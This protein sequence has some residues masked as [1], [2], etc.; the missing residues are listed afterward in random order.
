MKGARMLIIPVLL[1]TIYLL[2]SCNSNKPS[3]GDGDQFDLKEI[4]LEAT[5]PEE[6]ILE[7][8][9]QI[10]ETVE[11]D[12]EEIEQPYQTCYSNS[13]ECNQQL[14]GLVGSDGG[15]FSKYII[16]GRA[17]EWQEPA[18]EYIFSFTSGT[19]KL[20]EVEIADGSGGLLDVIVLD[21]RC[22]PNSGINF[23]DS[24]TRFIA[25]AE[26]TYFIVIDGREEVRAPF[27]LMVTCYQEFEICDNSI[28]DDN[29]TAIDCQDT[30]CSRSPS[31]WELDCAD[32]DDDDA[33][34]DID[35][36]DWDCIGAVACTGGDGEIGQSCISHA[37]C[38]TG[39]CLMEK[40]TGWPGG[41]C[42]QISSYHNCD[43][44]LCGEG[45]SCWNISAGVTGPW[46]CLQIATESNPCR[47]GYQV[48]DELCLPFCTSAAQCPTLGFCDYE[49]GLCT[50]TPT[51]ICY[52][53]SDDD[54]DELVDCEDLD[55][56]FRDECSTPVPLPG[57][58]ACDDA[59]QI[60]IPEG[61]NTTITIEGDT[62]SYED[63]LTPACSPNDSAD[64]VYFIDIQNSSHVILD[65]MGGRVAP[66]LQ[67][68]V[69]AIR[70]ECTSTDLACNND[71]VEGI[72]YHSRIETDL[73]PGRYYII[74]D[75]FD[76]TV[77]R[78]TLGVHLSQI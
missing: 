69:I 62:S 76:T 16:R 65:L 66:R 30:D 50:S 25:M 19:D 35:C 33:D 24:I 2:P 42:A 58:E 71:A 22:D 27:R 70:A 18:G 56:M 36:F 12:T 46:A 43:T 38:K 9:E 37:D 1:H 10:Y 4:E 77:G 39:K 14:D 20:V 55:C 13:I 6:E 49:T 34:G 72:Y 48:E 68:T 45:S 47:Q 17:L 8:Y 61:P 78:F 32:G 41:Y 60:P 40:A 53:S 64:V 15:E 21:S 51:E 67:D 52:N 75:G 54:G 5:S 7:Q 29:D 3:R 28:D 44:L 73:A 63:D 74:V 11:P 57:G 31:C 26:Q 23:G 59:V